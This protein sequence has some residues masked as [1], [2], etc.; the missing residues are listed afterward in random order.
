MPT[1]RKP[2]FEETKKVVDYAL[3]VITAIS[4]IV[5]VFLDKFSGASETVKIGVLLIFGLIVAKDGFL[6]AIEYFKK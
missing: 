4:I 3:K 1:R 2:T 5:A 6:K